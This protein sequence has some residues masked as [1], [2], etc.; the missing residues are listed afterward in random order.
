MSTFYFGSTVPDYG[1][2]YSA[3]GGANSP[4]IVNYLETLTLVTPAGGIVITELMRGM[5]ASPANT[6][7]TCKMG[8][9]DITDH[10]G[11]TGAPVLAE[12]TLPALDVGAGHIW[13]T[14]TGLNINVPGGRKLAIG[15]TPTTGVIWSSA[16]EE[17]G[18]YYSDGTSETAL[19]TTWPS[20]NLSIGR[21]IPMRA[22]YELT[23][24]G[25]TLNGI[26]SDNTVR[27]H[28]AQHPSINT[29]SSTGLGTINSLTIGTLTVPG[30]NI[31]GGDGP[32]TMSTG[33]TELN[34]G[35]F[36][37]FGPQTAT[38]SDGTDSAALQINLL[39]W[40][41]YDYVTVANPDNSVNSVL[42][43]SA[44]AGDQL[45]FPEWFRI[46]PSGH[47]ET[48]HIGTVTIWHI[49]STGVVNSIEVTTGLAAGADTT[50]NAFSVPAVTGA[51]ISTQVTSA[52]VTPTGYDSP[53]AI[54][55]GAGLEY[56]INNGAFTS[57]PGTLTPG[58]QF[59]LRRTSSPNNS[60]ELVGNV[61]VG[62]VQASW[63]VTTIGA[64]GAPNEENQLK[65]SFK[66]HMKRK[67]RRKL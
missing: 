16:R 5:E 66:G 23:G 7:I 21:V 50:P 17:A 67:M 54:S 35:L 63:S 29:I 9:Y 47:P 4:T 14:I 64:P 45:V 24:N 13:H 55:V 48:D 46:T 32:F 30:V 62:T 43:Q 65:R 6:G 38:A 40:F 34:A 52:A 33:L 49:S 22:G 57:S 42:H 61:T 41:G 12:V 53:A 28:S 11:I 39:P 59:R 31:P 25:A 1:V 51:A 36:P 26:N 27:L 18:S 3:L 10:P 60:T 19:P 58:Q 8:I 20:T 56:S 37:K 2:N 44:Q 15:T